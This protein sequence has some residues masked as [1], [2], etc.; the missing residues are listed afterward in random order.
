MEIAS[1]GS[2]PDTILLEYIQLG[3]S[4]AS[5]ASVT[6]QGGGTDLLD[7]Q[8][9]WVFGELSNALFY[10][11]EQSDNESTLTNV[12]SCVETIYVAMLPITDL[13]ACRPPDERIASCFREWARKLCTIEFSTNVTWK[14]LWRLYDLCG[15]LCCL[16][17][18]ASDSMTGPTPAE[19][20]WSAC[21]F[22]MVQFTFYSDSA[23][24]SAHSPDDET[25]RSHCK[26]TMCAVLQN[27]NSRPQLE[28]S[29]KALMHMLV[30]SALSASNGAPQGDKPLLL[31]CLVS[32]KK[33]IDATQEV[34]EEIRIP[35]ESTASAEFSSTV[36]RYLDQ[37]PSS[38]TAM[39]K[40]FEREAID[41]FSELL[42]V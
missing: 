33:F 7:Q 24:F 8:C 18:Q 21:L 42:T 36:Q 14:L 12:K 4:Y 29:C 34:L 1:S 22:F 38:T 40:G 31:G 11:L 39:S 2:F 3:S 23:V 13:L 25:M 16:F 20:V 35:N 17:A 10:H 37:A 26:E 32:K 15:R 41:M 6:G 19:D 27:F 5:L 9:H 28:K 30:L